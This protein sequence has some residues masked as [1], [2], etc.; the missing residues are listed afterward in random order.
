MLHP[1]NR[2]LVAL[3]PSAGKT[4]SLRICMCLGVSLCVSVCAEVGG[5]TAEIKTNASQPATSPSLGEQLDPAWVNNC[6]A[7]AG[8]CAFISPL[9]PVPC[10]PT[11]GPSAQY[12]IIQQQTHGH[13][14][15]GLLCLRCPYTGHHPLG[16][17]TVTTTEKKN[18]YIY[19]PYHPERPKWMES[20]PSKT[21]RK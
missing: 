1:V 16:N 13:G 9:Q 5:R 2:T 11:P 18:I 14:K 7:W 3:K 8:G 6:P 15:L 21:N 17:K 10:L 12:S 20:V 4:S 19:I